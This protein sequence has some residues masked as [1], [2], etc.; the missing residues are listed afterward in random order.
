[1]M[2]SAALTGVAGLGPFRQMCDAIGDGVL[3]RVLAEEGVPAKL[4]ERPEAKIPLQAMFGLFDR[5]A[6]MAGEDLFGLR[7]GERMTP[8]DFGLWARY[9]VSGP[10]LAA[11]IQRAARTVG[12]HQ[13]GATFALE[14]RGE[15][16]V[17]RY[18]ASYRRASGHIQH[19]DHVIAPMLQCIRRYAGWRWAP[20]GIE[21]DYPRPRHRRRLEEALGVPIVFDAPGLGIVFSSALLDL[22]PI[23]VPPLKATV[24]LT[25]LRRIVAARS[26]HTTAGAVRQLLIFELEE[27]CCDVESVARLLHRSNRS[28]QRDLQLEGASFRQILAEARRA[29][30]ERLIRGTEA[31]FE[32]IAWRLGYSE[33]AHFTYAFRKWAGVSPSAY[34][35]RIRQ[36]APPE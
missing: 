4:I 25:D 24:T 36:A 23:D 13:P 30:A 2:N 34:R 8:A 26:P 6:R 3:R 12:Y 1:M 19:T 29:E 33:H 14:R 27:T 21:L 28:I 9:V 17:W 7:L 22:P 18:Q 35:E 10:N 20:A 5:A 11:M 15:L 16:A 32:E 31:S